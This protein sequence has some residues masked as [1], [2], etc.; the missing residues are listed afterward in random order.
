MSLSLA[1]TRGLGVSHSERLEV[2][3]VASSGSWGR[4]SGSNVAS[5]AWEGDRQVQAL[6]PSK[7]GARERGRS[8]NGGMEYGD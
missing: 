1:N 8:R 6:K 2:L 7:G 4:V 3:W 5:E